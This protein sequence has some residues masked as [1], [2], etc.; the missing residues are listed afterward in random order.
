MAEEGTLKSASTPEVTDC[1][2]D[3]FQWDR[4]EDCEVRQILDRIADKWSLLIIAPA[5]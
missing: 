1:C 5:R 3:A 2:P 4:R